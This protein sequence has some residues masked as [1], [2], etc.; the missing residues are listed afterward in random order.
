MTYLTTEPQMMTAAAADAARIG[1]AIGEANAAAAGRI[2]AWVAAAADEVSAATA[3]LFGSYAREYQAVMS[4]LAAFHDRFIQALTGAASAYLDTEAAN[5]AAA[6][7]TLTATTAPA[8]SPTTALVMGGSGMPIPDAAFVSNVVGTYLTPNFPG[9]TFNAPDLKVLVNLGY[10]DPAYGYSTGPANVPTPFELFPPVSPITVLGDLVS[11][12]QQGVGAFASDIGAIGVPSLPDL[13]LSGT[14]SPFTPLDL[15]GQPPA[16]VSI[17]SVITGLQAVNTA[18]TNAVSNAMSGGYSA[19]LPTAD[20][21]SGPDLVAVLRP[22]PVPGRNLASGPR[23]PGRSGQCDR[24]SDC[25]QHGTADIRC[26]F[27]A[28]RHRQC[29]RLDARR[30]DR[31]GLRLEDHLAEH[32]SVGQAL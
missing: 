7:N 19:L 32:T 27:R 28:H 16:T 5:A 18:A 15:L 23:R 31:P 26:R 24:P 2:T 21:A 1:S 29:R 9:V 14:A 4:Q 22:Q 13:S 17:D 10:G 20:I 12:T 6:L 30:S 25:G 11:G 8:A 3:T